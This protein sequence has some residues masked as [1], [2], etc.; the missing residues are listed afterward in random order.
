M[1]RSSFR[2]ICE[3]KIERRNEKRTGLLSM[4][5]RERETDGESLYLVK[6]NALHVEMNYW[7][8]YIMCIA[9]MY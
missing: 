5:E 1:E 2:L 6:C 7:S 3:C 9:D 4:R 8:T